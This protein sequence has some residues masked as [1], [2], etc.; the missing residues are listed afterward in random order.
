[1]GLASLAWDQPTSSAIVHSWTHNILAYNPL[2]HSYPTYSEY[3]EWTW[4]WIWSQVGL[5]YGLSLDHFPVFPLSLEIHCPCQEC[6]HIMEMKGRPTVMGRLDR[7]RIVSFHSYLYSWLQNYFWCWWRE[8]LHSHQVHSP[9]KLCS[10]CAGSLFPYST[11]SLLTFYVVRLITVCVL[12]QL[13]ISLFQQQVGGQD[14]Q[15]SLGSPWWSDMLVSFLIS[16]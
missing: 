8:D 16:C 4:I 3:T 15:I 9:R 6:T 2:H 5:D 1:M 14:C 10:N 7:L 12:L 11:R 13:V